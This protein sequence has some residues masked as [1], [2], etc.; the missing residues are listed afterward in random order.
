M[1]SARTFGLTALA[2]LVA[3]AIM[4]TSSAMAT[5]STAFC[6][7]HEDPCQ[8]ANLVGQVHTTSSNFVILNNLANILCLNVLSSFKVLGLGNPLLMH[9]ESLT[10]TGCGTNAKHDNC[11]ITTEELP[12]LTV[13]RTSLNLAAGMFQSGKIR[14]QCPN[15]GVNCLLML[16]G[17]ELV[18]WG[19]GHLGEFDGSGQGGSGTPSGPNEDGF[20]CPE[21][22]E[23]DI[24][25]TALEHFYI[26]S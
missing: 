13:L 23:T 1:K 12:L 6:K 14:V 8:A 25:L 24:L 18:M 10:F 26:V 17:T 15:L 4:G 2:A 19:S 20:F 11:T 7:V 16:E 9:S 22:V 5:G 3:M 21:E